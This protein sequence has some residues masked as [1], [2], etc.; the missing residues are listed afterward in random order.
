MKTETCTHCGRKAL[1]RFMNWGYAPD[2]KTL[3]WRCRAVDDCLKRLRT[4]K[5]RQR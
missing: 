4:G 5:G 3:G 2:G 1:E